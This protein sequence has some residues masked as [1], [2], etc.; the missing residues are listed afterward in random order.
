MRMDE[1]RLENQLR[2]KYPGMARAA[3]YEASRSKAIRMQC[4]TCMGGSR[5]DV[6]TCTDTACFLWPYR[7]KS[8]DTE[9]PHGCIPTVEWYNEQ[10]EVD[11]ET[12]QRLA[13][14]RKGQQR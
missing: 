7:A 11:D 14:A 1:R 8:C 12:I 10:T 3:D 13:E 5:A 2:Q 6:K 9:R 4:L